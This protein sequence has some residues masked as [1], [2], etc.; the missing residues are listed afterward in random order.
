MPFRQGFL[1][2]AQVSRSNLSLFVGILCISI[3]PV[4][5]RMNLSSGLISAFYRMAIA[6]AILFPFAIYFKRWK[7]QNTKTILPIVI[8]GILFALDIAVWNV[9]IQ[10]SSATQATLLTN[11]SPIWVGIFSLMFFNRKPSKSFWMGATVAF[12]GVLIFLN[13]QSVSN[14]HLDQAFFLG[15]LSGIF[16]SLYI[17]VSKSV[18]EK[19][20]VLTFVTYSMMVSSLVLLAINWAFDEAFFGFSWQAWAALWVQGLVCQLLA[21]LLISY[22]TQRMSATKVSLSLLSQVFFASVFAMLFIGENI[23]I[24]Q[25]IGG[26]I[27]LLGIGITFTKSK[28]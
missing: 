9:S 13:V 18:L 12:V 24:Q 4:I 10:N 14:F 21:W 8:C 19:V 16:Y 15:V 2:F 1:N 26:L 5:I 6:F 11:L 23:T 28:E 20:N 17:L 25:I 22:S 7:I 3:F 27:I